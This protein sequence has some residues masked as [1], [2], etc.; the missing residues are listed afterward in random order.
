MK[1]HLQK[2]IN[3]LEQSQT[4][5]ITNY[6]KVIIYN[7]RNL[8]NKNNKKIKIKLENNCII[9]IEKPAHKEVI[10]LDI[11][12]KLKI[13]QDLYRVIRCHKA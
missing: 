1:F 2:K 5:N 6:N 10:M 4:V 7:N 12:L 13:N 3:H 9:K 11:I 8:K